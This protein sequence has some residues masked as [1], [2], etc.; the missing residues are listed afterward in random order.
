MVRTVVILT[1]VASLALASPVCAQSS[2]APAGAQFEARLDQRLS[3]KTMHDGD[4][5]TM[6]EHDG[7]FHHAPPA[8]KH[9]KLEGHVEN[10]SAAAP[11]HR[12]TMKV[13]LDDVVM[14]DGTKAPIDAAITSL[15]EFDPRSHHLRDAGIVLGGAMV[16]HALR[17]RHGGLIGA[18]AGLLLATHLKSDIDVKRGTIVHVKLLD[19][20][21]TVG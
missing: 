17:K 14:A 11:G 21:T 9:A 5:F 10:V 13:V 18:G 8:L 1:A 2:Y 15:R 12:A 20:V 3:S 19:P 4:R 6:T 7:F 16:G